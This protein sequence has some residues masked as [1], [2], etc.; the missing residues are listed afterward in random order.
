MRPNELAPIH[1]VK[2]RYI[3][4]QQLVYYGWIVHPTGTSDEQSRADG[5]PTKCNMSEFMK[6]Y[7]KNRDPSEGNKGF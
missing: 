3:Q 2:S 7:G 1:A 5:L 6:R 4:V